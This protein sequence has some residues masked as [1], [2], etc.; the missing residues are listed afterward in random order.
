MAMSKKLKNYLILIQAILLGL[1]LPSFVQAFATPGLEGLAG[2]AIDAAIRAALWIAAVVAILFSY[3]FLALYSLVV[4]IT[5]WILAITLEIPIVTG[6]ARDTGWVL[7]R[8]LVN[9]LFLIILAWIAIAT[10]LRLREYKT[11]MI[12]LKLIGVALLINF[13]PV[14]VGLVVD[15]SNIIISFFLEPILGQVG[16]PFIGSVIAPRAGEMWLTFRGI[17]EPGASLEAVLIRVVLIIGYGIFFFVGFFAFGLFGLIFILRIIAFWVLLILA[18]IAFVC[19]ILP[20]TRGYWELWWHQ[21]IQW[22]IIGVTAAFFFYLSLMLLSATARDPLLVGH[23]GGDRIERHLRG[24]G[25]FT[26]AGIILFSAILPVMVSLA[27]MVIGIFF[28][29]TTGAMGARIGVD[30]AKKGA[31]IAG[32]KVSKAASKRARKHIPEKTKAKMEQWAT[33]PTFD[34][35]LASK[36]GFA[37]KAGEVIKTASGSRAIK[38]WA[39]REASKFFE[40]ERGE[41]KEKA[42]KMKGESVSAKLREGLKPGAGRQDQV[43]A[44]S[45]IVEEGQLKDLREYMKQTRDWSSEQTDQYLIKTG[46]E[47][48]KI[49]PGLAKKIIKA[50][51]YL[52]DKIGEGLPEETRK[53]VGLSIEEAKAKGYESVSQRIQAELSPEEITKMDFSGLQAA[54]KD[55]RP[56]GLGAEKAMRDNWSSGQWS[57]AIGQFKKPAAEMLMKEAEEPGRNVQY[58]VSRRSGIPDYLSSAPARGAGLRPISVLSSRQRNDLSKRIEAPHAELTEDFHKLNEELKKMKEKPEKLTTDEMRKMRILGEEREVILAEM[59]QRKIPPRT[60]RRVP[61]RSER[62]GPGTMK[63]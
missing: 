7:T 22:A 34:Q 61:E 25:L 36:T 17:F 15:I 46:Q 10:I 58:M 55:K 14:L 37:G 1:F 12:F 62:E 35:R 21:L 28:G 38:R 56:G 47:A 40:A 42:D 41:V 33:M 51:P 50:T 13:S 31:S 4:V 2:L 11:G 52:A 24:A 53:Q 6:W 3:L 29:F 27:F 48:A 49:S 45:S 8:N 26:E 44:I 32:K 57:A 5:R 54:I 16:G 9:M 43:A 59:N 18:P 19:F 63:S 20:R 23:L 30:V 39:G 60:A